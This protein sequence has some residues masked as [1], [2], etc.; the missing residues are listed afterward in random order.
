MIKIEDHPMD[1]STSYLYR[2]DMSIH[3]GGTAYPITDDQSEDKHGSSGIIGSYATLGIYNQDRPSWTS[4]DQSD[5]RIYHSSSFDRPYIT[6][7]RA[8]VPSEE[9]RAPVYLSSQVIDHSKVSQSFYSSP[10]MLSNS[11]YSPYKPRQ[12]SPVEPKT[13]PNPRNGVMCYNNA[14]PTTTPSPKMTSPTSTTSNKESNATSGGEKK[15]GGRRQEK[16]PHSYINMIVQAI[17]STPDRRMTLSEI[18]KYLQSKYDFFNGDYSGWK[19]SIRHNLSLNECFKKLPKECGKPGKGHYWTIDESAEFMFEEEGS[20][21]RR[22]RGFRKKQM[23]KPYPNPAYY[24]NMSECIGSSSEIQSPYT[25]TQSY[26]TYE[27][28]STVPTSAVPPTYVT[29][30]GSFYPTIVTADNLTAYRP[31]ASPPSAPGTV[32]EYAS[33]PSATTAH[34]G[35]SPYNTNNS[36]SGLKVTTLTQMDYKSGCGSSPLPPHTLHSSSA[37]PYY[38]N[39]KYEN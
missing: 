24:S 33:Y 26:T 18:Y 17:K 31:Y 4:A 14:Q 15:T 27:C 39:I 7:D 28:N 21:R 20:S 22:P 32:L 11:D 29:Q 36:E 3:S 16:P 34:Y 9:I 5:S 12:Q 1:S 6:Y 37:V 2:S 23:I 25:A 30:E 38:E 13:S 8:A 35:T 10:Q 19:N